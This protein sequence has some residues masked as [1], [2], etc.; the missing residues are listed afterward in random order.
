MAFALDNRKKFAGAET[1]GWH[2]FNITSDKGTGIGDWSDDDVSAYLS[3]GHALNRGTA[4]G[5]M[6]EAVDQSF[7]QM[8]ESD[9]KA[10][11]VYVRSVP[12]IA[13]PDLTTTIAPPAP[14]R[15]DQGSAIADVLVMR[16]GVL[17][18]SRLR[19]QLQV[20]DWA[21]RPTLRRLI[22]QHLQRH[23]ERQR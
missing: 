19:R 10:L 15:P 22:G 5:P 21:L 12:A 16:G 8:S 23:V 17:E 18:G 11:T 14:S 1:A 9:I 7:S 20:H 6:G 3:N 2:A 13:A 4:A